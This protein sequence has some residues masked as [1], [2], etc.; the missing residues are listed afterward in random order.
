MTFALMESL[1]INISL[2]LISAVFPKKWLRE[3]FS[4]KGFL[5]VLIGSI[6]SILYQSF[7]GAELP[8][9]EKYLLWVGVL[10]FLCMSLFFLFHF[11]H[12]LQVGLI[13]IAERFTIFAYVYIPI[14]FLGLVVVIFR[15]LLNG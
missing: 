5:V 14:G 9:R 13:S 1:L 10:V 7:L 12:R 2:V 3:G 6:A 8:E 4:Y 11:V 15:N